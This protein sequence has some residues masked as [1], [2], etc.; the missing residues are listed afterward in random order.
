MLHIS[1]LNVYLRGSWIHCCIYIYAHTH[2]HIIYE[3]FTWVSWYCYRMAKGILYMLHVSYMN[4]YVR[5]SYICV[6]ARVCN[7]CIL[8]FWNS[9]YFFFKIDQGW[10]IF[11]IQAEFQKCTHM[12]TCEG[13]VKYV[14]FLCG[15]LAY[16]IYIMYITCVL[17]MWASC[18]CY[19]NRIWMCMFVG[20][21]YTLHISHMC[22]RY[23][24]LLYC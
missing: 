8:F 21:W 17:Y 2:T 1:Y 22:V 18:I 5:G 13:Y 6:H 14:Y 10:S 24:G 9:I 12:C 23:V 3:C 20:L 7:I 16:A 4:V 19:T 15:Y 11:E